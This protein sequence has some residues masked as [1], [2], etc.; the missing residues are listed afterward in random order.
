MLTDL[1]PD[2]SS[3]ALFHAMT[4]PSVSIA[5]VASGRKLII[6]VS[7]RSDSINASL[8]F[9][10]LGN[11]LDDSQESFITGIRMHY[12]TD[13][14]MKNTAILAPQINRV[15]PENILIPDM[16]KHEL[17]VPGACI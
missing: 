1:T 3:M 8:I 9:F 16:L 10:L 7:R 17:S 12:N 4:L 15:I 11:I 14:C 13:D 5:N 6:S 2:N